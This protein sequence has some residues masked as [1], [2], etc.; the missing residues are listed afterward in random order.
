M[1]RAAQDTAGQQR[2]LEQ[3]QG[4]P[5]VGAA[6]ERV[7]ASSCQARSGRVWLP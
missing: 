1:Q 4:R 5:N 3:E 7:L 2:D 6:A